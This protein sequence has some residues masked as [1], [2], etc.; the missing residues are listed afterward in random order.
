M[1]KILSGLLLT[2]AITLSICSPCAAQ[3]DLRRVGM[4]IQVS[5]NDVPGNRLLMVIGDITDTNWMIGSGLLQK[6]ISFKEGPLDPSAITSR[7]LATENLKIYRVGSINSVVSKC[8]WAAANGST[9]KQLASA[10]DKISLNFQR[11]NYDTLLAVIADFTGLRIQTSVGRTM[12]I[13]VKDGPWN[14]AL[15]AAMIAE[16]DDSVRILDKPASERFIRIEKDACASADYVPEPPIE[17]SCPAGK[18]DPRREQLECYR[19]EDLTPK[20]YLTIWNNGVAVKNVLL[21]NRNKLL[22]RAKIGN[23]LGLDFGI[24]KDIN[25]RGFS[26]TEIVQDSDDLY[27]ERT[28]FISYSGT[29]TVIERHY[30]K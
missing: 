20:G 19:I 23:Y 9:L 17:Y 12:S 6:R 21:E 25:E 27:Y 29:R 5:V 4:T 15:A 22:F 16:G 2:L 18:D 28:T 24:I 10:G 8:R 11:L 1:N 26:A 7:I 13:R 14:D 30:P 3:D